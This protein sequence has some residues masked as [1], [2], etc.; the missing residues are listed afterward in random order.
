[1]KELARWYGCSVQAAMEHPGDHQAAPVSNYWLLSE[2]VRARFKRFSEFAGGRRSLDGQ[3]DVVAESAQLK[4]AQRER[5]ELDLQIKRGELPNAE[6]AVAVYP[7]CEGGAP[8]HP[9]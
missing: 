5:V 9:R 7:A 2:S 3:Y 4:R 6:D 8:S 1:M